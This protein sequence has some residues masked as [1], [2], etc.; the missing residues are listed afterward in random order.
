MALTSLFAE[1]ITA[2]S[3]PN[4]NIDWLNCGIND[5][6]WRPPFVR[7]SD[8]IAADLSTAIKDK[9][10]PFKACN[11]YVGLFEK[12]GGEFNGEEHFCR[13]FVACSLILIG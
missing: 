7:I 11:D 4:G 13:L 2:V 5:G 3:G 1:D 6:G 9:N 8:L 12:Y 10:S